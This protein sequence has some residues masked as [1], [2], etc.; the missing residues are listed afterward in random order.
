MAENGRMWTERKTRLLLQIWS[1]DRIQRQLQGAVRNNAVYQTIA[2]ELARHG[3]QCTL[4]QCRQKIKVLKK[5]Y[6]SI[7]DRMRRS[8][9]SREPDEGLDLPA[10]FPHFEVMDAIM[11]GRAAVTP[12]HLLDSAANTSSA[13]VEAESDNEATTEVANQ[14]ITSFP[15]VS[16]PSTTLGPTVS[17]CLSTPG[18]AVSSCP[19]TPGPTVSSCPSTPAPAVSRHLSTP[20]SSASNRP[21]TPSLPDDDIPVAKKKERGSQVC[22][23]QRRQLLH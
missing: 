6:K 2:D 14:P 13:T 9:A 17:S 12:V 10:D 8:S 4:V 5:R 1:K 19:S 22:S 3:F 15:V 11:G 20:G 18:P 23:V 16:S 21:S 7:A